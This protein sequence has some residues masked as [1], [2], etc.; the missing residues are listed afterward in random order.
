MGCTLESKPAGEQTL[1][2]KEPSSLLLTL[3]VL[4]GSCASKEKDMAGREREHRNV[5][6]PSLH[7]DQPSHLY[8]SS[9]ILPFLPSPFLVDGGE[10][11]TGGGPQL[12][13]CVHLGMRVEKGK[14]WFHRLRL[15][16]SRKFMPLWT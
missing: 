4:S 13:R 9:P 11:V 15:L 5:P 16:G 1:G 7:R 10:W 3:G 14:G 8:L 2:V 6:G 12:L